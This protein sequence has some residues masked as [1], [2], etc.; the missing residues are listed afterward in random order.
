MGNQFTWIPF[1]KEMAQKLL[2]YKSNRGNLVNWIYA[3]LD[4]KYI[5]HLKDNKE[6]KRVPDIDPFTVFA[7]FNRGTRTEKRAEFCSQFKTF[8]NITAPVPQDYAG[9]PEMNAEQSNF[10]AFEDRR[11]VGDI[12]RLWTVF[13]AAVTD[14]DI[15]KE[16]DA[17]SNQ[18]LIRFNLT[19]GLFWIRPDKFLPLD[20]NSRNLLTTL[21]IKIDDKKYLLYTDYLKVMKQL[22]EKM[23][24]EDLGYYDF[25][26]FSHAAYLAKVDA[27]NSGK[28]RKNDGIHF[29]M[30]APGEQ[31]KYW[32][33]YYDEGIMAIGWGKMGNL[34]A[35]T[36]NKKTRNKLSQLYGNH[37]SHK[38]DA[39]M[40]YN[41]AFDLKPGDIVFAKKGRNTI[42]GR[43]VVTSDYF[44][45]KSRAEQPNIRKVNWTDKG[46]WETDTMQ[47]TKTLT[48]ITPYP[49]YVEKLNRLIDGNKSTQH[50]AAESEQ[51]GHQ[52]YW[53]LVANPKIWSLSGMNIG[54]E[55]DYTL[56]NENGHPR[57][58]QQNFL[59][60]K[61]GDIVI[62]YESTPTKQIVGLLE[63]PR[64]AD[65][66]SLYFQMIE[67]LPSPI[68]YSTL[69]STPGLE[70]MEYM[71]NQQGSFFKVTPD[72]YDIII[73]LIRSDNP[74]P[75]EE[76]KVVYDRGKFL[77]EVYV[78]YDNYEQLENLLLRKKNLI[79]QGAPGVGKTFAARRLAYAIMGEKDDSRVMQVQFHQNY[80]YEDFV[81]GYKPNEDGGF[82][83]KN[84]IFYRFCK[85]AAADRE[86]K[87]F[88]IIDE[89][90]RG[91]LSKIFGELLMLIE[92]DYRDKPIQLSYKDEQFSVPDNL[93]LIGMMNTADRSLA[94]IDYAL[95]RRFSFF[96]MKPG[97]E[98]PAF[99]A[100]CSKLSDPQLNK[101]VNAIIE[102]NKVIEKDD[103][104]GSG[105]CIGH[106][107]LCNL[108]GSYNLSNIV[109]YDI[110]P[111]LREY[112]FDNN[113]RFNQEAQ[114][115][116][117]SLK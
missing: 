61:A 43:G 72:E 54:E 84:G 11:K 113:D 37:S 81:M 45:V 34:K 4:K 117:D 41:F 24:T 82:E 114:K 77:D 2:R 96:E 59:N 56:Y 67:K 55:Q 35:Y 110:I 50:R 97:F 13:E 16:Y 70:D 98:N 101:L 75:K 90:N 104:L 86:H 93:Y 3:N 68:D 46:V 48:D 99:K 30:Y 29:W 107:Y 32:D 94:M 60:A 109:E 91:N 20:V 15:Q 26:G 76:P 63:I 100:Y 38:Q 108:K 42:V 64:A 66:K 28:G 6:G 22:D 31:A 65:E 85:R 19:I 10:M 57:R 33:Q 71:K 8:L 23:S 74:L 83:L 40:L 80:N 79:L 78:S 52:Q 53:W 115:L 116:R 89:I 111:M 12:E 39:C 5:K 36:D 62:G 27:R 95:R 103:S 51:P 49:D 105:F 9:I 87:Y 73:D 7:L 88:F 112:W 47:V 17:L 21:G 102:L 14:K 44:Y 25:A 92:Y 1:Y 106:S 58:I 69:K 18:Y